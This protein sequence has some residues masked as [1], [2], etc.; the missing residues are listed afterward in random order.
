MVF[1]HRI[2]AYISTLYQSAGADVHLASFIH[3]TT[4]VLKPATGLLLHTT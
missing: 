3:I 4:H 1:A 2:H